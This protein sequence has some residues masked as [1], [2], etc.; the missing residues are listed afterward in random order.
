MS[1]RYS[2]HATVAAFIAGGVITA[3]FSGSLV[4][5][6]VHTSW[7]EVLAVGMI[8]PCFTWVVQ[9]SVSAMAMPADQRRV[10]WDDL[11]RICLIGSI[12]LLPAA[13]IN[14]LVPLASLWWSAINVLA[15]VVIMAANLFRRSARHGIPAVWPVSWCLT[16][17][18]NMM[19]FLWSSWAWWQTP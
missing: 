9:L 14:L 13:L 7:M 8:V 2:F 5:L 17:A 15:S 18:V 3:A 6:A 10:Y 16:I 4:F 12:A 1:S 11:G 19:L